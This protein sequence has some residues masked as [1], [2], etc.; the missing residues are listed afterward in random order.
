MINNYP[1]TKLIAIGGQA[2]YLLIPI[3]RVYKVK[4]NNI[5]LAIKV[6]EE[7]N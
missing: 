5:K 3:I 6:Y 1:V 2:K 4:N 7:K